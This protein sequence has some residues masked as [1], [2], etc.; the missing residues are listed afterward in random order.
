MRLFRRRPRLNHI[1][2]GYIRELPAGGSVVRTACGSQTDM[3]HATHVFKTE[4][5]VVA[6]DAWAVIG[7]RAVRVG[8]A[9]IPLE[10]F[11]TCPDCREA[12]GWT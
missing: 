10:R 3:T 5:T 4:V 11:V 7:D 1:A 2:D 6:P 12:Q 8:M 9:R